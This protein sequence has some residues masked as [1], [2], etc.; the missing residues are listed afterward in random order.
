[1]ARVG[2]CPTG[3]AS[4]VK[5]LVITPLHPFLIIFSILLDA[6]NWVPAVLLSMKIWVLLESM[7]IMTLWCMP[8]YL[9]VCRIADVVQSLT[10]LSAGVVVPSNVAAVPIIAA[11]KHPSQTLQSVSVASTQKGD[12]ATDLFNLLTIEDPAQNSNGASPPQVDDNSWA[13]FQYIPFNAFQLLNI[14]L[15]RLSNLNAFEK[16]NNSL[17]FELVAADAME[18]SEKNF[19]T[20]P[21][22][23]KNDVMAGLEDLFK[24][25]PPPTEKSAQPQLSDAKNNIMSLF[26]KSTMVSPYAL[27]Q[28]QMAA[29]LAQQQSL[30]MAATTTSSRQ[31]ALLQSQQQQQHLPLNRNGTVPSLNSFGGTPGQGWPNVSFLYPGVTSSVGAQNVLHQSSQGEG[32]L[33]TNPMGSQVSI[34]ASS[35]DSASYL[36]LSAR[37]QTSYVSIVFQLELGLDGTSVVAIHV[38][39]VGI[40]IQLCLY[41]KAMPNITMPYNSLESSMSGPSSSAVGQ[42][43]SRST[44]A[45]SE[46]SSSSSGADYDFSSLMAGVFSK[47]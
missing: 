42:V 28:Q 19:A 45:S 22:A 24:A 47:Q 30:M 15:V 43:N 16:E 41:N 14:L 6:T 32:F 11:P 44:A 10:C 46:A 23:A 36:F 3:C 40:M 35:Y 27:H 17:P 21:S 38:W 8:F 5:H 13:A 12:P 1:M 39:V 7:R 34:G 9:L 31:A 2:L 33:Q 20:E 26:E 29:F 4:M 18:P 37:L 25:S